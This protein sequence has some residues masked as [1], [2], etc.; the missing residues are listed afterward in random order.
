[1]KKFILTIALAL[2]VFTITACTND[3]DKKETA[4]ED[5][6]IVAEFE[7]GTITEKEFYEE[8]KLQVGEAIL[9]NLILEKVLSEKYELT[10]EELEEIDNQIKAEKEQYAEAFDMV[11][12]QSGLKDEE[13]YRETL[14]VSKLYEKAQNQA[15]EG[16]EVSEEDI[17]AEFE[18]RKQQIRVSHILVDSEE[19]ANDLY[20]QIQE[21]A[22]F[23]ELAM[24]HSTDPGSAAAGGDLGF[25]GPDVTFV[26]S[27]KEAAFNLEEGELSKP[28]EST[29][30]W[31]I[32]KVTE[33]N[34]DLVLDDVKE[35]IAT[36]LREQQFDQASFI[37][38]LMKE[39][40]VEVKIEE[41]K[42]MYT[43]A[44]AAKE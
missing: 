13:D 7:N 28:V 29:H 31:H 43:E 26:E 6:S 3:D 4:K 19:L 2:S 44:E 21:G 34:S 14:K 22:D 10:D 23:A 15:L 18:N 32:I 5:E 8:M 38:D 35:E 27:F 11:I 16:M 36:S 33:S 42:D 20:N 40:N 17:Q 30:G 1:M 39:V 41:F 37:N 25:I 9:H 24:E 12:A